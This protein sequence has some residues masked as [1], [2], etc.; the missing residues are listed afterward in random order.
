MK[1]MRLVTL[2]LL[3]WVH[4]CFAQTAPVRQAMATPRPSAQRFVPGRILV[5]VDSRAAPQDVAAMF[6]SAGV[7]VIRTDPRTNTHLLAAPVGREVATVQRLRA[8]PH[9]RFAEPDYLRHLHQ[10]PTPNDPLFAQQ[11][12]LT[13]VQAPSGWNLF[14]AC[15]D[16]QGVAANGVLVSTV[17]SGIDLTNLDLANQGTGDA[18]VYGHGTHVAGIIAAKMNDFFGTVG[19]AFNSRIASFRA[20]D[21]KGECADSDTI[22]SINAAVGIGAKVINLSLGSPDSSVAL[23]EAVSGAINAGV[24]V[25]ASAGNNGVIGLEYPAGCSGTGVIAVAASDSNDQ[26]ATFS[27]GSFGADFLVTAPGVNIFSTMSTN[28]SLALSS[29]TGTGVMS[30]TSMAAPHVTALVALLRGLNPGLDLRQLKRLIAQSTDKV[31]GGYRF[32][33]DDFCLPTARCGWNDRFGYGRINVSQALCAASGGRPIVQSISP[34]GGPVGGGTL[35]TVTG[36]CLTQLTS[37]RVGNAPAQGVNAISPSQ[38][39]LTTPVADAGGLA[40]VVVTTATGQSLTGPQSRF[41]Y[42]PVISQILPGGGA[43]GG[44]TIVTIIGQGFGAGIGGVGQ[45]SFLFGGPAGAPATGVRCTSTDAC[46]MVTPPSA[47]A[48]VVD[49]IVRVGSVASLPVIADRFSYDAPSIDE[50]NPKS[51][52]DS[53]RTYVNIQGSNFLPGNGMTVNFGGQ[54]SPYVNCMSDRWCQ[55]Y[56]PSGIGPVDIEAVVNGV[57]SAHIPADIYTFAPQPTVLTVTPNSGLATGGDRITL[58]GSHFAVGSSGTKVT[59]GATPAASV[60]CNNS[61]SCVVASPPG[62]GNVDLTVEVGGVSSALGVGFSYLP[63]VMSVQPNSGPQNGGTAVSIKGAGFSDGK[64]FG[65]WAVVNFGTTASTVACTPD[66]CSVVSPSGSGSV[67]VQVSLEGNR[68]ATTPADRFVYQVAASTKGWT[69]WSAS[70]QRPAPGLSAY[71]EV[72]RNVVLLGFSESG[73]ETWSW[74]VG[75]WKQLTPAHIPLGTGTGMVYD[76]ARGNTVVFGQ[77]IRRIPGRI[78]L[79]AGTL[80]W[81][82]SDWSFPTS[83]PS[84]SARWRESMV[85]D[86]ARKQVLLF[87]GCADTACNQPLNDMWA[88]DGSSWHQLSSAVLPSARFDAQMSR[89]PKTGDVLLF[90]GGTH[91]N[92]FLNE[93]WLWNGS[94]WSR[95]SPSQSPTAR[96]ALAMAPDLASGGVVLIGGAATST[97]AE[98]WLWDGFAW[99]QLTLAVH[100]DVF[101]AAFTPDDA[102]TLD[103]LVDV[104]GDV[105]SWG[106]RP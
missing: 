21:R 88:W 75:G 41:A 45:P 59:F 102:Q 62:T 43:V 76:A 84:P 25:V 39:T 2:A 71:D 46:E 27:N 61:S 70:D 83:T 26:I 11:W 18:D 9:V 78:S 104:G 44:G 63:V 68:S 58:I 77:L 72:R 81:D 89:V 8:D 56:S 14:P 87:G 96:N 4:A 101:P 69:H 40:D 3:L 31:G 35:V 24:V 17:D 66:T 98:T 49:V 16:C 85:Y 22:N 7:Q 51:G 37:V 74:S 50:V 34:T 15:S 105:W 64:T 65:P 42:G 80:L 93:T 48:Q 60:L 94:T 52:P 33:A 90:G 82:G 10:V 6:K 28:A 20:C 47:R 36:A 106:G 99:T 91:D 38:I 73:V 23:C 57:P 55:A 13:K 32:I 1:P 30:G 5:G 86:A 97:T 54:P 103:W 29:P 53:G 95:Q 12:N 67:D 19:V 79:R 100:P 92:P